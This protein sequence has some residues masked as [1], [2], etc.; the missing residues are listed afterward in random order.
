MARWIRSRPLTVCTGVVLLAQL[1]SWW[2]TTNSL[3]AREPHRG[4]QAAL[5]AT[6]AGVLAMSVLA[7]AAVGLL[8]VLHDRRIRVAT[9]EAIRERELRAHRTEE[10]VERAKYGFVTAVSHELRTPLQVIE[11]TAELLAAH[12]TELSS[13]HH[14]ALVGAL[15][16][17]SMRLRRLLD[18]VADVDRLVRGVHDLHRQLVDVPEVV[19]EVLAA[20][21]LGNREVTLRC[22]VGVAVLDRGVARRILDALVHNVRRH[23]PDGTPVEVRA[24][25]DRGTTELVV[26]DHG[27]GVP[28]VARLRVFDPL[29][30]LGDGDASPGLGL[31]L[32][33]VRRLAELH[34]GRAWVEEPEGGGAEFHVVLASTGGP[35][36]VDAW[37]VAG[38][39]GD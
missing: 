31:G 16:R 38:A 8:G 6:A 14:S 26:R 28:A 22:D 29:Y 27:Q 12:G 20:H 21:D 17:N 9:A 34:G 10:Q 5:A 37:V 39:L 33:L 15:A 24:S 1:A 13:Q 36:G 19:D 30:R 25:T 7:V 23:T 32:A 4:L 35:R 18:D 3:V 11:G 2:L